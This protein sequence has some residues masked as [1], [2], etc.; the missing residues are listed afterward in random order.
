M[1]QVRLREMREADIPIIFEHRKEP[2]GAELASM[3]V[4]QEA[5]R[6]AFFAHWRGL[7]AKEE[8]VT[9]IIESAGEIAGHLMCFELEG[10]REVGYWLGEE[11]WGKGVLSAALPL[12]IAGLPWRPL[13]AVTSK[14]NAPSLRVLEKVGFIWHEDLTRFDKHLAR[15]KVD[16]LMR[17]DG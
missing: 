17:L 14:H 2:A 8:V 6:D 16:C 10:R 11:H 5:N 7:I 13:Y 12:F 9:Q 1:T 15:T 3:A 4:K